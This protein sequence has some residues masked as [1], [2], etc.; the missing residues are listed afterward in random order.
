MVKHYLFLF[1]HKKIIGSKKL[2]P[3]LLTNQKTYEKKSNLL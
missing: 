2:P 1:T 3:Q